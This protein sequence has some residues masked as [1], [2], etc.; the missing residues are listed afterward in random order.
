MAGRS[1]KR[2]GIEFADICIGKKGYSFKLINLSEVT[3]F[4]VAVQKVEEHIKKH[5]QLFLVQ[6]TREV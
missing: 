2:G 4:T 3:D 6:E 5:F 1:K